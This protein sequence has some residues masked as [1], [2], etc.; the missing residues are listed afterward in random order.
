MSDTRTSADTA[1][2]PQ[3]ANKNLQSVPQLS[4]ALSAKAFC[5]SASTVWN[6]LYP[7]VLDKCSLQ[8]TNYCL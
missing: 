6:S 4:L 5:V 1:W 8:R 2:T 3:S 7:F